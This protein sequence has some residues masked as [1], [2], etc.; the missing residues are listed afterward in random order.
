MFIGTLI[1]ALAI[2]IGSSIGLLLHKKI[3]EKTRAIVFQAIGLF[4]LILGTQMAF[5][6]VNPLIML[7]SIIIGG[8]LGQAID[9]DSKLESL[10]NSLKKKV[11][12]KDD[13]FTEGFT[14]AFLLFCVGSMAILGSINDGLSGDHSLLF[15]KSVLD[16]FSSIALASSLGIGVMFSVI[17]LLIYQGSISLFANLAQGFFRP[18]MISELTAVGGL[19]VVGIG[20]NLLEIKR[21]KVINL[22]PSLII[23]ILLSTIIH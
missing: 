1:N 2:V 15:T 13:T 17:P 14:T 9:L 18:A 20:I 19:L 11:K 21:I 4:T 5:K 12:V 8:V 6:T 16:G 7:F 3:P 22:L 10:T 23:A